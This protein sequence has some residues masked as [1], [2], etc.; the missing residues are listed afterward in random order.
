MKQQVVALLLLTELILFCVCDFKSSTRKR[1]LSRRRRYLQ[2]PEGSVAVV[3]W[4]MK[5][6]I[7]GMKIC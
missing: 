3:S 2:F 5:S 4:L 6:R 7:R 1:T